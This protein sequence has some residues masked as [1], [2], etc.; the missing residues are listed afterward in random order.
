MRLKYFTGRINVRLKGFKGLKSYSSL[1]ED[2]ILDWLTGYK[3]KG[4]YIDIGA[5]HPDHNNNTKLFYERGWHGINIEP[6]VDGYKLFLKERPDDVNINTGVGNGELTYFEGDN[7]AA[8]NTFNAETGK[9][10]GL[11]EGKKIKLTPLQDIFKQ[12][13]LTHVDFISIDVERFEDNVLRSNDWTKYRADVLC[14]EGY[15]YP[16]LEQFGYKRVFWDGGNCY[17]KYVHKN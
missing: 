13:G 10:R 14:I 17:Y 11:R 15:A 2:N 6:N 12:N 1:G 7:T 4:T 3:D 8:G 16:Y 5:N 9:E